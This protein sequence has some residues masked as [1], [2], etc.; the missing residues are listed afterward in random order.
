MGRYTERTA[1][2][3]GSCESATPSHSI[4]IRIHVGSSSYCVL[5]RQGTRAPQHCGRRRSGFSPTVA[6]WTTPRCCDSP[7]AFG[8]PKDSSRHLD[9]SEWSKKLPMQQIEHGLGAGRGRLRGS[10]SMDQG[11]LRHDLKR[12]ARRICHSG[13]LTKPPNFS[14]L[15]HH[16]TL[17]CRPDSHYT[18][19]RTVKC[20]RRTIVAASFQRRLLGVAPASAKRVSCL[21]NSTSH[22]GSC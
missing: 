18:G 1:D 8:D 6:V 15:L 10:W 12:K 9:F 22:D 17:C 16:R 13:A 11:P 14:N 21:G 20:V 4:S 2:Q 7:S 3:R 5:P 19:L